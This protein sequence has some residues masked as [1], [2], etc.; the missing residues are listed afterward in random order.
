[1]L[2]ISE[3][4]KEFSTWYYYLNDHLCRKIT[5]TEFYTFIPVSVAPFVS[6]FINPVEFRLYFYGSY[7]PGQIK[8]F[9]D[10]EGGWICGARQGCFSWFNFLFLMLRP[11]E[12]VKNNRI[13]F[14]FFFFFFLFFFNAMAWWLSI[15]SSCFQHDLRSGVIMKKPD[16]LG[17]WNCSA[18]KE[19]QGAVCEKMSVTVKCMSLP[20]WPRWQRVL[21]MH[22]ELWFIIIAHQR[23]PKSL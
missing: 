1:M 17:N 12:F 15:Y 22:F 7:M 16:I 13:F 4:G 14:L 11:E 19:P 9:G 18:W 8:N 23:I 3:T 2:F 5:T 10:R 6:N 20:E 21:D